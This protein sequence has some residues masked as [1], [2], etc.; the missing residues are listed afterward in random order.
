MS[1]QSPFRLDR[2]TRPFLFKWGIALLVP[3]LVYTFLWQGDSVINGAFL[4][5]LYPNNSTYAVAPVD[6]LVQ[7]LFFS[8]L[9]YLAVVAF[10]GYLVAV[11]NGR[12]SSVAVWVD[13]LLYALVPIILIS[14]TN[15][16]VIGIALSSVVWGVYFLLRNILRNRARHLIQDRPLSDQ[17]SNWL[18]KIGRAFLPVQGGNGWLVLL[19]GRRVL[20]TLFGLTLALT[21]LVDLI[22]RALLRTG[23][24]SWLLPQLSV[25]EAP[26]PISNE[27]LRR[28]A[29]AGSFSLSLVLAVIWVMVDVI[30]YVSGSFPSI[31]L[32]AVLTP[33]RT[34][35]LLAGGYF[36]GLFAARVAQYSTAEAYKRR[37]E[38]RVSKGLQPLRPESSQLVPSDSPLRSSGARVFYLTVLLA[39]V[40][41]YPALDR[42]LFSYGTDGRLA[43]Y[44]DAGYY[45]ILA[46]GLNIVVGFAGLLD[47]GYV[48]FFAIGGYAWAIV[49][50]S[51]F[52]Q[53]FN[54][55]LSP[56]VTSW[57]FWPMLL[58][59]ALLAAFFGVVLGLPTLRL[60]GDYL[61][62]VT[63]GFGEIVPIV[64]QN[65]RP[66]TNGANGLVGIQ[67]PAFFGLLWNVTTP[68]PYYYLILAL[69][70]FI[71]FV[72][73]RMRD[74]RMGRAWVA[75]REDEIA[76]ASSGIN[77]RN[78]KLLAFGAGAF[79]SGIAGAYHGAKLG[80]ISPDIFGYGDSIIYLAMVVIGGLGSIP[81]VIV[82][83][84]AVY[85]LDVLILGQLDTLAAE[86]GSALFT[87]HHA[88]TQV[89]PGFTFGNI[90]NLIFGVILIV[91]MVFRPEGLI[92]SARRKRELHEN[93]TEEEPDVLGTLDVTLSDPAFE[94]EVRVE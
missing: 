90:R 68:T 23:A 5:L 93:L 75:I 47:L 31:L 54:I 67:S 19:V 25:K 66:L 53:L 16:L 44:G 18:V 48:A 34:V 85:A 6:R 38:R 35:L 64:A 2:D 50:S 8:A 94:A 1:A 45:V 56:L 37:N 65:L 39:F 81:G 43:G 82:G 87:I 55:Y 14:Q 15:N 7:A 36:G 80:I 51:Q 73:V 74:S 21:W 71:I 91:I 88:I 52:G 29:I 69:I 61:A 70:G 27:E 42:F 92:P 41:F 60:R 63:L 40:V 13:V 49:G 10:G 84:L 11:D 78:T 89:I 28:R 62:I 22:V 24:R 77:L 79:F 4:G 72:A 9:F 12:R 33:A 20:T 26:A 30:F 17:N 86:P 32:L 58:G 59:S 57:L 76:A 83:A 3:V 46:L